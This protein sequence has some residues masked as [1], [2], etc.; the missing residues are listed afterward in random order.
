YAYVMANF[1]SIMNHGN[2]VEK[3]L[4]KPKFFAYYHMRIGAMLAL[5]SIIVF[6]DAIIGVQVNAASTNVSADYY[7]AMGRN[8]EAVILYEYSWDRYRR[9]EKAMNAVAHLTLADNQ[10]TAAV[11]TL[12]RS[13][14]NGPSVN[15]ILLL[16]SLMQQNGN[17]AGAFA[18]LEKG[19]VIFPENPYLLNNISRYY[20]RN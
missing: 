18:V 12:L 13:F 2:Q 20:S 5:L 4:F 3:I 17:E 11:N 7:Y 10:P 1:S 15:D 6:A 16:S 19:L 14:E 9:N 8:R